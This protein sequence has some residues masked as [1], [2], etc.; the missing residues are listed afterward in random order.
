MVE[1]SAED[2]A[3]LCEDLVTALVTHTTSSLL[4]GRAAGK[5]IDIKEFHRQ[6]L[7]LCLATLKLN[8]ITVLDT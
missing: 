5:P 2:M 4:D 6:A 3:M 7:A 1:L 8:N